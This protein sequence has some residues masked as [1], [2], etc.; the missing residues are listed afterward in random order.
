MKTVTCKCNNCEVNFEK[1]INEYN[2]SLKF[3]RK[4]YCSRKCAGKLNLSNFKDKRN[5]KPPLKKR[6]EDPFLYYL[7][8]CKRRDF[9]FDLTSE[10]LNNLWNLQ[11][12]K[13]PYTGVNLILNTHSKRNKDYR[14]TASLDRIDSN[15]GYIKGN[16]Q[17][18]SLS[19]NLM[20]N[21][22]SQNMLLEFLQII[23]NKYSNF[24]ED[25]T[26]SSP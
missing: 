25:R 8:N 16:V 4:F 17:F 11:N 19:I 21:S 1:P 18:V 26:I 6:I 20:K 7:R 14:Y 23:A 9:E 24:S 22:M 13:C 10:Y 2:R 5:T 12:K 3:N 15:L